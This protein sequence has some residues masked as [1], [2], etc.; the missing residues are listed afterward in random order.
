VGC[1]HL[2]TENKAREIKLG[3]IRYWLQYFTVFIININTRIIMLKY[4]TRFN[5]FQQF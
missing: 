4:Y 2:V 5:C 1:L 3:N